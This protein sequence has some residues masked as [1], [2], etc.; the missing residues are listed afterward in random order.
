MGL[1]TLHVL[2]RGLHARPGRSK[3]PRA[4]THCLPL[5]H[6]SIDLAGAFRR[7]RWSRTNAVRLVRG[8]GDIGDK[9]RQTAL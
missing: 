1:K 5:V 2:H 4:S 9:A 3:L 7:F 8:K 6:L